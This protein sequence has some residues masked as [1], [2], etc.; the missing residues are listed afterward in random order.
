MGGII[1]LSIKFS[2]IYMFT[3]L[4]VEE[5]SVSLSASPFPAVFLSET[6]LLGVYIY[7]LYSVCLCVRVAA[8]AL[9]CA[10][11]REYE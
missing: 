10:C 8:C 7:D 6:R 5:M 4:F 2:S 11:A 1:E 3:L 9:A